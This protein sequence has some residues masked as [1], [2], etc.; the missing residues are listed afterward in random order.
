VRRVASIDVI[1]NPFCTFH[2]RQGFIQSTCHGLSK[3]KIE[4]RLSGP[5]PSL[6]STQNRSL[7]SVFRLPLTE[8]FLS[9]PALRIFAVGPKDAAM[10]LIGTGFE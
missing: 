3:Y 2:Q 6:N 5:E 4:L 7:K 10:M 9:H 1:I 8:L